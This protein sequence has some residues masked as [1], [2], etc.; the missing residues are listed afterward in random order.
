M[1]AHAE[2]DAGKGMNRAPPD[3]NGSNARRGREVE[4]SGR[5]H[6]RQ[7]FLNVLEDKALARARRARQEDALALPHHEIDYTRLLARG[8]RKGEIRGRCIQCA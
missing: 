4:C 8:R 6:A 2:T 3:V 7:T 1:R 5:K